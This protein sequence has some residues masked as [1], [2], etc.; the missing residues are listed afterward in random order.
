MLTRITSTTSALIALERLQEGNARFSAGR[1]DGRQ[2]KARNRQEVLTTG[3]QPYATIIS[4]SDSRVPV[5]LIFDQ[6]IGDLFV[7]RVAGNVCHTSEIG[8][9]EYGVGHLGTPLCVVL[10]HSRCGVVSAVLSGAEL[11]DNVSH[12]VSAII[13]TALSVLVDKTCVGYAE[14]LAKAIRDNVFESIGTL[15]KGSSEIR[16]RL[17]RKQ[18]LIIGAYYELQTGVV[19]W[20]G[21]HPKL[22]E[23]IINNPIH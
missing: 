4:C 8:S 12:L 15:I 9:A 2:Q 17:Q 6:G 5:E 11:H 18:L 14:Q 22:T 16:R 19:E 21:E 20:L 13:P 7:I 3:N 1:P 23:L 10:G